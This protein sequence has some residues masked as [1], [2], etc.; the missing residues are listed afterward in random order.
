[1][2][3][4]AEIVQSL[5]ARGLHNLHGFG[6]KITGLVS[7][8]LRLARYLASSDSQAW[9]KRAR[10]AWR[11]DRKRLC[12]GEH[13]GGCANCLTWALMWRDRL[14]KRVERVTAQGT[15]MLLF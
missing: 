9:S 7:K 12:G 5:Y 11:H 10:S 4:A 2:K 3:E 15:Q 13:A 6:F 14:V 1:M 8:G